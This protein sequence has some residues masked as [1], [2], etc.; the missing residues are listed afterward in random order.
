M[1]PSISRSIPLEPSTI[2][3]PV[4]VVGGVIVASISGWIL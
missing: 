4:S 1:W 2:V 3:A